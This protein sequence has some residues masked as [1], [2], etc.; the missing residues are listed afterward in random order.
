MVLFF[1]VSTFHF[2]PSTL[3]LYY[4]TSQGGDAS[5]LTKICETL[6]DYHVNPDTAE[7]YVKTEPCKSNNSRKSNAGK[8][9]GEYLTLV[10]AHWLQQNRESRAILAHGASDLPPMNDSM[11][12]FSH[13]LPGSIPAISLDSPRLPGQNRSCSSSLGQ[14][15]TWESSTFRAGRE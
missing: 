1:P 2:P 3:H 11:W 12:P 5:V 15:G 7:L 10:A 13:G 4:T 14:D 8:T 6:F 9:P